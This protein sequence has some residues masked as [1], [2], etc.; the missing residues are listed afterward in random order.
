MPT[1]EEQARIKIDAQ[2]VAAGWTVLPSGS[3]V[4]ATPTALCELSGDTGRADYILYLEGVQEQSASYTAFRK[5]H[6]PDTCWQ[7]PL[8]FRYEANGHQIQFTDARAPHAPARHIFHLPQPEHLLKLLPQEKNLRTQL[9]ELPT[10]QPLDDFMASAAQPLRDCQHETITN[11]ENSLANNLPRALIHMATGAG[12]TFTAVTQVYRLL[13]FS[14]ARRVL[15]LVDRNSLGTQAKNEFDKYACPDTNRLFPEVHPVSHLGPAG[16]DDVNEV[17]ISTIQRRFAQLKGDPD[18]I[19]DDEGENT[20]FDDDPN[21]EPIEASYNPNLPPETFD[22]IIVDECHRFIYNL[23][24]QVLDQWS[25]ATWTTP[26]GERGGAHQIRTV[27]KTFREK[28]FPERVARAQELGLA[29]PWVPKTLIFAKDDNHA[30]D[31]VT[32]VRE[33]FGKGNDFCKKVT[34]KA[35]AKP[36]DIIKAFRTAPEKRRKPVGVLGGANT[37]RRVSRRAESANQF[38]ITG[39]VE[40]FEQ[41]LSKIAV[42]SKLSA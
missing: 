21:S 23:W 16:F 2:L 18:S 12:K 29:E 6:D 26:Q 33:E 37:A 3:A 15:F 14:K 8:P 25:G 4:S 1:P 34:Y 17:V 41:F 7:S 20:L 5:W 13:K 11:L 19:D 42:G 27:I 30:E 28:L 36:E 39:T 38:R 31:I 32:H 40:S 22:L 10:A 24:R 9:T 35:G